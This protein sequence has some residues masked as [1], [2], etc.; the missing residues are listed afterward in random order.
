MN[1]RICGAAA[2]SEA[3]EIE[4]YAGFGW[5]VHDCVACG[6]RFTKHDA[7]IYNWLHEQSDSPYS[8]YRN[9]ADEAKPLFE[10]GDLEGLKGQLN[11]ISKYSFIIDSI[12]RGPKSARVLEMGCS[13]GQ[14]TAYFILAGYDI[15][16]TDVS[17]ES[18]AAANAMFGNFFVI[19]D[20]PFVSQKAPYDVIYHTGMVGCVTDPIT[21][22]SGL[23]EML[24]PG[25]Q[26]LFNSPNKDACALRK[27]LWIDAAPPPDLVTLFPP[28]FW[29]EHFSHLADV[30][31]T[32]ETLP[33]ERAFA[34]SLRRVLGPPW[35]K[36]EP[37]SLNASG[38][39]Y[40]GRQGTEAGQE[41]SLWARF[42]RLASLAA[43]VTGVAKL[44]PSQAAPF[45]L[46]VTMT[47][48]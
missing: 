28:G 18:I 10:Q 21:M 31:E 2:A 30:T 17:S 22:T 41:N 27:Q 15:L 20:S 38:N 1:C 29:I 5:M 19:A 16:G 44:L 45:G 35:K 25:G 47:K 6:C 40:K 13:R 11:K 33:P 39:Y 9:L 48:K 34:I 42:E 14:L 24:M 8:L 12:E 23:L 3:G 4:Y 37:M 7:A 32:I 36:P 46:L 26:L 43:R